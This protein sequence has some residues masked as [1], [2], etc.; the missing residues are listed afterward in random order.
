M[1]EKIKFKSELAEQLFSEG[2]EE[3]L[4]LLKEE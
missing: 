3:A 4:S 2:I 1:I